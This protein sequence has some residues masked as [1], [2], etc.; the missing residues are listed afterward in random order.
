MQLVASEVQQFLMN[1]KRCAAA[2][3]RSGMNSH[4]SR[5]V[6]PVDFYLVF[7]SR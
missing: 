5:S 3:E 7:V 6:N 1:Q 2:I 4:W